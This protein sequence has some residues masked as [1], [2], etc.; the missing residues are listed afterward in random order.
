MH[1]TWIMLL[2]MIL[3]GIFSTMNNWA[4]QS[5]HMRFSL[6]DIYMITLMTSWMFVFMGIFMKHISYVVYGF[7]GVLVSFLCIRF[8]L[9]IDE[10]DF[11]RGMI[12]HHSMALTMSDRLQEKGIHHNPLAQLVN[13]ILKTQKEEIHIMKQLETLI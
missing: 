6:N 8:Q 5:D 7:L 2:S 1:S 13:N 4:F 3:S 11:L 12:I 10:K 9:F